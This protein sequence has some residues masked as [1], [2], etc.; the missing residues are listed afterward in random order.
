MVHRDPENHWPRPHK[1]LSSHP[2]WMEE[3]QDTGQPEEIDEI[4]QRRLRLRLHPLAQKLK[5]NSLLPAIILLFLCTSLSLLSWRP[6]FEEMFGATGQQV[7]AERQYWRLLTSLLVHADIAHLLANS[8]LFLIFGLFLRHYFG[9]W[10]FP[11]LSLL[12]GM[13]TAALSLLTYPPELRLIG[14]SGMVYF[15]VGVW[16][17]LFIRFADYL[18]LGHRLMRS[19]AFTLVV[20]V[21]TQF[22]AHVSYRTHAI[23]FALG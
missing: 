20:L 7:F 18:S 21:P 2:L 22:E 3:T 16:L 15:M 14:A 5:P 12:G 11:G 8:G 1:P 23:G 4:S 10:V 19:L 13:A 17:F 9:L 6:G